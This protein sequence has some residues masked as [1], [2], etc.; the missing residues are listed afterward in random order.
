[1]KEIWIWL[2]NNKI[3]SA[4]IIIH[5]SISYNAYPLPFSLEPIPVEMSREVGYNLIGSITGLTYRDKQ[6]V[7]LAF[8]I[9]GKSPTNLTF[10]LTVGEALSQRL[11]PLKLTN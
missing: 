3:S 8:T 1:M 10:L 9:T 4:I 5:P 2:L 7:T 6:L 11:A